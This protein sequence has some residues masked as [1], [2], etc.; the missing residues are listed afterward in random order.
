MAIALLEAGIPAQAF[1]IDAVDISGRAL[2]RARKGEA[3]LGPPGAEP[4]ESVDAAWAKRMRASWPSSPVP[5]LA[6]PMAAAAPRP[7]P[8]SPP[9]KP[10]FDWK[11]L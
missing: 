4:V 9:P 6:P 1:H 10:A 8:P 3:G 7:A 11:P 5:P 2:D